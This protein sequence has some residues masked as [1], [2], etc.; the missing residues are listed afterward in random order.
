MTLTEVLLSTEYDAAGLPARIGLELW[1]EP[2]SP[3]LRVAADREGEVA[4]SWDGARR[5]AARMS[6][7]LDGTGG[8]G[9]YELLR[10]A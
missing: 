5:E 6:F 9:E 10:P 4:V 8:I 2:D 1:A 3:P 7:R